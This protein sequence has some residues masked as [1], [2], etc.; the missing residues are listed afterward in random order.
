[1]QQFWQDIVRLVY[2]MD[3]QQW[4]LVLAGVIVLG[5]FCMKGFGS[6]SDY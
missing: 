1:M 6:R 2:S 3:T 4:M 5:L